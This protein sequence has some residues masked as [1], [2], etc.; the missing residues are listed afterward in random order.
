MCALLHA[1]RTVQTTDHL[2]RYDA[3]GRQLFLQTL[4]IML[5]EMRKRYKQVLQSAALHFEPSNYA[6]LTTCM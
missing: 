1:A 6:L 3:V 4:R 2:L 5:A